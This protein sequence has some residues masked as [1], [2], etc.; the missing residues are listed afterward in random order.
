GVLNINDPVADYLPDIFASE[1]R[2]TEVT[3]AQLLEH[4]AGLAGSA[5][6]EYATQAPGLLPSEY[7]SQRQPFELRWDPGLHYSYS[8]GGYTIA[9]AV[10]EKAWGADFDTLIRRELL[11]PLGMDETTFNADSPPSFGP[12]GELARPWRMPVRPAGSAVTTAADLAQVLAVLL[13]NGGSF[14]SSESIARLE[15]GETGILAQ[16]GGGVGAYGLGTFAYVAGDS[17]L[18]A[19]WGKTEGFRATL[20]YTNESSPG[21]G[22]VLLV[23]TADGRAIGQLRSL[24]NAYVT[25]NTPAPSVPAKSVGS[26]PP[27]YSG[28]YVNASHDGQQR[29]WLFALLGARQLSPTPDGVRVVPLFFGW[30]SEWRRLD[31]DLYQASSIPVPSGATWSDGSTR[32]WVDGESYR[33]SSALSVYGQIAILFA[34]IAACIISLLTWPFVITHRLWRRSRARK[35]LPDQPED[36]VQTTRHLPKYS[37]WPHSTAIASLSMLTLLV[38]FLYHQLVSDLAIVARIGSFGPAAIVLFLSSMI[39]PVSLVFS[40]GALLKNASQRGQIVSTLY[41]G[42]LTLILSV[43]CILLVSYQLVPLWSML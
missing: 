5:P 17:V 25:D 40:V 41:G 27:D 32:Y 29:A 15:R 18:R 42:A 13:D 35:D 1:H 14:L 31:N 19:H 9:G 36:K 20:A 39:L 33:Q 24:L 12:D 23:D 8:N 7:V 6:R 3:I 22:Y 37:L 30:P 34:G 26:L 28:V 16:A 11:D 2:G 4:T 10:I 43:A 38:G 21:S